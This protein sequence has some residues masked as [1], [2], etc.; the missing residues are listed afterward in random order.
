M[1]FIGFI[2][3]INARFLNAELYGQSIKY[4]NDKHI[5]TRRDLETIVRFYELY[6]YDSGAK[7]TID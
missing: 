1:C 4:Q 6:N 7:G 5:N 3:S 2:V